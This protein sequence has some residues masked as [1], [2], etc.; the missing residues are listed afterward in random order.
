[1]LPW[2]IT[3][4]RSARAIASGWVW[5]TWTKVIPRSAAAAQ[6]AAHP[7]AQELVE[8]RERL[9]EQQDARL[10]DERPGQRHALLLPAR[11]LGRQRGRRGAPSAR[12]RAPRSRCLR[13]SSLAMPR[14][15]R[16]K[17]TLSTHREVREQRV[18]LE[19]HRR[20]AARRRQAGHGVAADQDVAP[21]WAP[22]GP[23][24]SAGSWSCRSPRGRAG[25]SR[26]RAG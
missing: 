19:H 22:R 25:S 26:P 7:Q 9:V 23:R 12:A 17:A 24:S 6:L 13:R 8:G 14:I 20:A 1:M 5:V 11:E 21:R 4:T 16:L 10:G 15:L 2:F 3:T 18:G